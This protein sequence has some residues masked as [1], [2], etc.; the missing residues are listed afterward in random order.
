MGW[1]RT[2]TGSVIGDAPANLLDE[3]GV[4]W[5]N[6]KEIPAELRQRIADCYRQD[7]E[8]EP[9]EQELQELLDFCR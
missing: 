9:T 6:P 5:A 1:W 2:A 3:R 4:L 7:F 8:R